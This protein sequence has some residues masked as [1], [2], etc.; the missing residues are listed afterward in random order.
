MKKRPKPR[1]RANPVRSIANVRTEKR[2]EGHYYRDVREHLIGPYPTKARA[3]QEGVLALAAEFAPGV[4]RGDLYELAQ[5]L[6]NEDRTKAH[7]KRFSDGWRVW[8]HTAGRYVGGAGGAP[9]AT[10]A[11]AEQEILAASGRRV[12]ESPLF[13]RALGPERAPEMQ[14]GL[15]GGARANPAGLSPLRGSHGEAVMYRMSDDGNVLVR[16]SHPGAGVSEREMDLGGAMRHRAKLLGMGYRP[17]PSARRAK[18]RRMKALRRNPSATATAPATFHLGEARG[19]FMVDGRPVRGSVWHYVD[20]YRNGRP[21][22]GGLAITAF[23][24]GEAGPLWLR[25]SDGAE[26][27]YPSTRAVTAEGIVY[28]RAQWRD[29]YAGQVELLAAPRRAPK[30]RAR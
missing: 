4:P 25:P 3:Q 9:F 27:D 11:E 16:V 1:H 15:F 24:E 22:G 29:A 2:A 14:L 13:G 21:A 20:L 26:L 5:A 12:A 7:V 17:N 6:A 18:P 10:R 30:R 19:T 28:P 8:R 23:R